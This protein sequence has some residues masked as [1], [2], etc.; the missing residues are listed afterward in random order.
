MWTWKIMVL[1]VFQHTA[2]GKDHT[3]SHNPKP[4]SLHEL[5]S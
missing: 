5:P 3:N 1:D 2:A 4:E